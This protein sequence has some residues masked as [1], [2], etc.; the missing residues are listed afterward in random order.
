[1]TVT[2]G[3]QL[4]ELGDP[5]DLEVEIDVLSSDAVKIQPGARVSLERWGGDA[6]LNGSVRL[7][8]PA[9]FTKI[10]ALGVEEQRVNILA[11]I[12]D[13]RTD[14]QALGDAYRV[15]ARIV[16]WEAESVL[17]APSGA[18]FRQ[19]ENWATFVS[20]NG[21]ARLALVKVGHSNGIETEILEGVTE[22][23]SV[24]VH[25]SDQVRAGV[26]IIEREK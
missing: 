12:D 22:G 7:V 15:E 16:I 3:M 8:E 13:P 19:A 21:N 2:P 18:L 1:M 17:K 4:L 11:R 14:W 6:P 9:A 25:P 5:A 20:E 24:I 26:E 10:S 23:A